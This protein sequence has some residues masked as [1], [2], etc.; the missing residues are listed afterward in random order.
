MCQTSNMRKTCL[1]A[2]DVP[3]RKSFKIQRQTIDFQTSSGGGVS[4]F[5]NYRV[6]KF[7]NHRQEETKNLLKIMIMWKLKSLKITPTNI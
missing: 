4:C 7:K 5:R 2:K 1:I 3:S 6:H